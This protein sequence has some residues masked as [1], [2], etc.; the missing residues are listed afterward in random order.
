MILTSNTRVSKLQ[1]IDQIWPVR[2]S[3]LRSGFHMWRQS[4][5]DELQLLLVSSNGSCHVSSSPCSP[6]SS[7]AYT[8]CMS[9]SS[10][11]ST[12]MPAR[13]PI[14]YPRSTV[15]SSSHEPTSIAHKKVP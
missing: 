9:N 12:D 10:L 3:I 14:L 15:E 4:A 1:L 2:V 5:G 13:S 7:Y 11:T 6:H 8:A